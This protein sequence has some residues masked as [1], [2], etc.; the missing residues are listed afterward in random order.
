MPDQLVPVA[1]AL[2][3]DVFGPL[4][5]GERVMWRGRAGVAEYAFDRAASLP[6][7][8]LPE[9]TDILVTDRRV[10]YAYGP[11]NGDQLIT[12]GELRWLWPQYLRL[13][14]GART[15]ERG[16]AASQIQ[17]VC[18]ASDGSFPALVFAG[19]D[20]RTV[21][22]ADRMAN[23]LRQAIARF[24]VDHAKELGLSAGQARMLSRLLIG[25][26]FINHQGGNGQTVSLLGAMLV[27]RPSTRPE[28]AEDER[29]AADKTTTADERATAD[30]TQTPAQP[31]SAPPASAV[32]HAATVDRRERPGIDA[33]V[34]RAWAAARAERATQQSEPALASRAAEL[35][36]RIADLVAAQSDPI[37]E[38]AAAEP[39]PPAGTQPSAAGEPTPDVDASRFEVPTTNLTER[40]EALRRSAARFSANSAA[41]KV[42]GRQDVTVPSR[43]A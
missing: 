31:V 32:P 21:A 35:A 27:Q 2:S 13:Q 28:A 40:A 17:L 8:T 34:S 24:R 15:A 18:G 11:E 38:A 6:R 10:I 14:P 9:T 20:L 5:G 36:A 29:P 26:E 12:S 23:V 37:P 4:E 3:A 7:W 41:T 22:D 43:R 33:D 16:A 30:E 1:A 42:V 19:G 39:A 25:P